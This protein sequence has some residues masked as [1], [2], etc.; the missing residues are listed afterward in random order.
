MKKSCKDDTRFN[1]KGQLLIPPI[2]IMVAKANLFGKGPSDG[3]HDRV[4]I[5]KVPIMVENWIMEK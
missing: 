1:R 4:K 5:A 2:F 3:Y